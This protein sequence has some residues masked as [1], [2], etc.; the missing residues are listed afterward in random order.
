[1]GGYGDEV[2]QSKAEAMTHNYP[3]KPLAAK[4]KSC[5]MKCSL[6]GLSGQFKAQAA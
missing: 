6:R 3:L 2:Q 5:T 4:H 1:M